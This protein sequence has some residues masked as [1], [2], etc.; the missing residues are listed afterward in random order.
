VPPRFATVELT[1]GVVSVSGPLAQARAA[2]DDERFLTAEE[3]KTY[4]D[5]PNP[6]GYG[7]EIDELRFTGEY[8]GGPDRMA[9][10]LARFVLGA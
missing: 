1:D 10:N 9:L 2:S 3:G 4:F 8:P 7:V 5:A 6:F